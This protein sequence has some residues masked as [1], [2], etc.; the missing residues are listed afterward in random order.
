MMHI[1][2]DK[3]LEVEGSFLGILTQ[4]QSRLMQKVAINL[5]GYFGLYYLSTQLDLFVTAKEGFEKIELLPA[6]IGIEAALLL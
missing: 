3:D 5:M 2:D 1:E 6:V 4:A